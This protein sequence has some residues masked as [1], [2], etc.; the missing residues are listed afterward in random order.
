[1]DLIVYALLKSKLSEATSEISSR[2]NILEEDINN[3]MAVLDAGLTPVASKNGD[4]TKDAM[5][6]EAWERLNDENV[7]IFASVDG[8]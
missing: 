6:A 4:I 8:V 7:D 3:K 2:M 1:M 5:T